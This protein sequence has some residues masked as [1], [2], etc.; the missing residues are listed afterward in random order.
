MNYFLIFLQSNFLETPVYLPFLFANS[1][2]QKDVFMALALVTAMNAITHP[3]VFFFI[4]NFKWNYLSNILT[5]EAFAILVESLMLYKV[6]KVKYRSC[7]L[8]SVCA[9]LLSWQISPMLTYAFYSI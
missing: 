6:S 9:N 7:L 5:A 8:A 3:I 4:M 1:L 2:R